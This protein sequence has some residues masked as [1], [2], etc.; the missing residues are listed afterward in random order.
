MFYYIDFT[1]HFKF[2]SLSIT[3]NS[4][5]LKFGKSVNKGLIVF[6]IKLF[7]NLILLLF[8]SGLRTPYSYKQA[9]VFVDSFINIDLITVIT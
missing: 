4:I 6:F 7:I 3:Y 5:L 1:S 8:F 9:N 2:A